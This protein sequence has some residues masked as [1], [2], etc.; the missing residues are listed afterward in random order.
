MPTPING[1]GASDESADHEREGTTIP[2]N[3]GPTPEGVTFAL[4][5]GFAEAQIEPL[6]RE[7]VARNTAEGI[8]SKDWNATWRLSVL[9]AVNS[10]PRPG[11]G[12]PVT[13]AL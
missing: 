9:R 10:S 7:F 2:A 1:N 6:T 12:Q 11:V 5:R 8:V 4:N 13:T 3:W